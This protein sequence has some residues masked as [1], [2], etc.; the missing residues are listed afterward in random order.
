MP[1]SRERATI[2]ARLIIVFAATVVALGTGC[3][4]GDDPSP[5]STH[6]FDDDSGDG[7]D[8]DARHDVESPDRDD[9]SD[10]DAESDDDTVG[11]DDDTVA[12][13]DSDPLLSMRY[14][15]SR[16]AGPLRLK[17]ERYD[18]WHEQWHQPNYGATVN[19]RFTS[20]ARD[21]VQSYDDLWDSTLWTGTY[22]ASQALRYH[23]TGEAQAKANAIRAVSALDRTL[24]VTGRPGFIARYTG[25]MSD[26]V[27]GDIAGGCV[28]NPDWHCV[29]DGDFA[30]DFW[31]GDTSHDMYSG[32]FFGMSSPTI[33]WTTMRCAS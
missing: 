27:Y 32:W 18:L 10:D 21:A 2:L 33:S 5:T 8:D 17:A 15:E 22:L 31:F 12:L 20:D 28:T 4:D 3:G 13:C 7:V 16:A 11:D 25:P 9:D 1:S 14:D 30:G 6:F 24:H 26:P 29:E 23:V 19:V